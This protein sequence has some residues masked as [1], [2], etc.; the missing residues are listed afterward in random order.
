MVLWILDFSTPDS[1]GAIT[2]RVVLGFGNEWTCFCD[3]R[4]DLALPMLSGQPS[5]EDCL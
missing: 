1:L 2:N 5:P 3:D 4:I